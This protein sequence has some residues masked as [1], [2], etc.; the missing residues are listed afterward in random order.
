M[1]TILTKNITLKHL[2]PLS[3]WNVTGA[4]PQSHP[5]IGWYTLLWFWGAGRFTTIKKLLWTVSGLQWSY[6]C[7]F[8]IYDDISNV[9]KDVLW[10]TFFLFS[11][12]NWHKL[13]SIIYYCLFPDMSKTI[14]YLFHSDHFYCCSK[15]QKSRMNEQSNWG[16]QINSECASQNV[17]D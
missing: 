4:E 16:I 15:K 8:I 11:K 1:S 17:Q 7:L 5:L 13:F 6:Y 10:S 2:S 3:A 14:L 12:N 9:R